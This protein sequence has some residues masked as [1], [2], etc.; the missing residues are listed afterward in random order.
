[1]GLGHMAALGPAAALGIF[2]AMVWA[3]ANPR[4][5]ARAAAIVAGT[6]LELALH[7]VAALQRRRRK[8]VHL[9]SNE[10]IDRRCR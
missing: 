6:A 1:M 2:A 7:G 5:A 4:K 3:W 8:P 9:F 10:E